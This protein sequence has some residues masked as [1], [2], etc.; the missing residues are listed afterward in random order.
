M[1]C[2]K[3]LWQL[4]MYVHMRKWNLQMFYW[5]VI[6][7][8]KEAFLFVS[9][10]ILVMVLC[11]FFRSALPEVVEVTSVSPDFTCLLELRGWSSADVV[12]SR[13]LWS[14]SRRLSWWMQR[15][16]VQCVTRCHLF[17]SGCG[18][19]MAWA[20]ILNKGFI[21]LISSC[22]VMEKFKKFNEQK[23]NRLFRSTELVYFLHM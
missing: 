20:W 16:L 10:L 22:Q 2:W 13:P 6:V 11:W 21:F 3:H 15:A 23:N 7:R 9:Y 18:R 17:S 14:S 5:D 19:C 12:G 1:N 4:G 8:E